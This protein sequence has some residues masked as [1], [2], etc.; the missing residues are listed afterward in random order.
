[1]RAV[2]QAIVLGGALWAIAVVAAPV[3]ITSPH[4]AI[5]LPAAAVYA[6]G[7][8]VCHQIPVRSFHLAGRPL[9]VC[10]RCT[11]LYLSA[12]AGGLLALAFTGGAP[13]RRIDDRL[14]LA[15]AALPTALSWSLEHAGLAA[16]S[17]VIRAAAA[18]PLGFAAAWVV[19]GMLTREG[20]ARSR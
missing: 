19:I 10:G 12:L 8:A 14:L 4:A 5:A 16:Q 18:L 13:T 7:S 15:V 17:N 2:A 11:G 9:A 3:A 6:A 1:M 20:T